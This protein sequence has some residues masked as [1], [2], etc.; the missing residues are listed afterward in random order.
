MGSTE[1]IRGGISLLERRRAMM[2]SSE[3]PYLDGWT[4]YEA[5]K[6]DGT[7][8]YGVTTMV[9]P[10]YD[11]GTS[12]MS[13][14]LTKGYRMCYYDEN[15]Q[16]VDYWSMNGTTTRAVPTTVRYIRVCFYI[17]DIDDSYIKDN[18]HNT[19]LFKGKNI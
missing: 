3:A 6:T 12:A 10:F 18:T 11:K 16:G 7:T 17:E 1:L 2:G 15:K 4:L 8:Q 9:S 13:I 19:Y 14:T 5:L